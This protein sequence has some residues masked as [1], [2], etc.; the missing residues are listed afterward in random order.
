MLRIKLSPLSTSSDLEF[1]MHYTSQGSGSPISM[2]NMLLP[3]EL[4]TA[5]SPCPWRA[6]ITEVRRSG[7]LVPAAINVTPIT[8]DGI[9]QHHATTVAHQTIR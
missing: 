2:S 6:T 9:C 5:I 7:M 4:D 1:A 3:M 8:L